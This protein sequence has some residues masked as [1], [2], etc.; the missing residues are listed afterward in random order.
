MVHPNAIFFKI[1]SSNKEVA[2][3]VSPQG[4]LFL[5]WLIWGPIVYAAPDIKPRYMALSNI[6]IGSENSLEWGSWDFVD[7]L[8][9]LQEWPNCVIVAQHTKPSWEYIGKTFDRLRLVVTWWRHQ[10]ETFSALLALCTGNSPV[11]VI[12]PHKGQ[13]REALGFCLICAWTD[14]WV[15][16]RDAGDLRHYRAHYDV[17]VMQLIISILGVSDW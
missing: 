3:T 4:T 9:I 15:N 10:M 7:V 6:Y 11:P 14:G 8:N 16:N 2:V 1:W 5:Y 13:R 17:T 12:S